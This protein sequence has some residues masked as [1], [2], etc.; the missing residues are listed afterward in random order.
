M[1]ARVRY[2]LPLPSAT[3]LRRLSVLSLVLAVAACRHAPP[4]API[5]A[6]PAIAST[7]GAG[8]VFEVRVFQEPEL[9]GVFQVGP[10][11]DVIFPLCQRVVVSG[12]TANGAAE[13][14]RACLSDGFMRD[15]QVS[16]LVKEYNSKK[17]FVFGEVQKPGTFAFE[18]GMSIVQ[19]VTIA[20][21]FTKGAAQNSTSVTRRVNGTEVKVK[22]NVQDIALG[23][24]PNFTLEPGDI[25]F[26]PESLF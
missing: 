17:V 20:G 21:G 7:L 13:K 2:D 1:P 24:A 23:K 25:V 26:V 14:L 3:M 12:L 10:Q 16:V 19:A 6:A 4:P 5:P 18:D 11:G 9:S 22:V 8:D 15:P